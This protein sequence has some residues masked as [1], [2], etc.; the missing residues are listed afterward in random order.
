MAARRLAEGLERFRELGA[1]ADGEVGDGRP[2]DAIADALRGNAFD[3]V[4]LVTFPPGLSRWL[5]QDLPSR[6]LRTF[7][8]PV[9]HLVATAPALHSTG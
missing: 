4:I 5:R 6:V 8:L 3:E 1:D 2:M 9:T 7:S